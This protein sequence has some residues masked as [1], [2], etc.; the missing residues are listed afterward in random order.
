MLTII[1]SIATVLIGGYPSTKQ[2]IEEV[3]QGFTRPSFLIELIDGD[4][5]EENKFIITNKQS[6]HIRYFLPKNKRGNSRAEEQY[7]ELE[8]IKKLFRKGYFEIV[9]SDR[10]A[11]IVNK[12]LTR[13]DGDI[14]IFLDIE[15]TEDRSEDFA[16]DYE[17][18]NT[19]HFNRKTK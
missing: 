2:Y 14:D 7:Q 9:E 4:E 10:V 11:K 17:L 1:N 12:K 6:Y 19:L 16:E 5:V 8:K 3:P 13:H 15:Y 18:M